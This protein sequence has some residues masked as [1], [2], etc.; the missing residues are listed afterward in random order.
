MAFYVY[1]L[2]SDRN[3]TLYTGSTDDIARR[4]WEHREG[5]RPGFTRRHG[6][7]H[8]VWYE[9]HAS[10]ETA[11]ARERQIKRWNRDWKLRLIELDNPDWIDLYESLA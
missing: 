5:V 6:V 2:A 4:I 11:F 8:L 7:H 1:I 9:V 10:R 3:G